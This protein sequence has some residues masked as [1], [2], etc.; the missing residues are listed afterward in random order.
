[1]GVPALATTAP[2][3]PRFGDV[4]RLW[5][6][7]SGS[8]AGS[9][10]AGSPW[11]DT[12]AAAPS[13]PVLCAQHRGAGTC[14]TFCRLFGFWSLITHVGKTFVFRSLVSAGLMFCCPCP[15]LLVL[16]SRRDP[17][18]DAGKARGGTA[19][20][21]PGAVPWLPA[22]SPPAGHAPREPGSFTASAGSSCRS[23][24]S[25]EQRHPRGTLTSFFIFNHF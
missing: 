24:C 9:R 16:A 22:L 14:C 25:S 11:G 1:M 23:S 12:S 2:H 19:D 10:W 8:S 20:S 4:P 18:Y 5:G 3:W 17:R 7:L 6:G 21:V 13:S 15:P